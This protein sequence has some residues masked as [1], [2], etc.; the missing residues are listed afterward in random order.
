MNGF[1]E[2][3]PDIDCVVVIL[4]NLDPPSAGRVSGPITEGLERYCR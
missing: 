3:F 1:L 4:A 2:I